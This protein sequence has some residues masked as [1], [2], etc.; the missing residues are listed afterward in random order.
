MHSV[1][2]IDKGWISDF[3][4]ISKSA[5]ASELNP[6]GQYNAVLYKRAQPPGSF[7][8]RSVEVFSFRYWIRFVMSSKKT[9][10]LAFIRTYHIITDV[11]LNTLE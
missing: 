11:F 8:G 2:E 9:Y 5:Q 7:E 4:K 10:E 3:H 1:E 6:F